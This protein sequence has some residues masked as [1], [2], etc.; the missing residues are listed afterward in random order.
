MEGRSGNPGTVDNRYKFISKERD[1]ETG[2]DWFDVRGFDARIGRFVRVDP[3]ADRTSLLGWSPY[4]YAFDNPLK[5]RDET[6]S[7]P[8]IVVGLAA[9]MATRF[10]SDLP[11]G[12]PSMLEVATVGVGAWAAQPTLMWALARPAT[13]TA[14]TTGVAEAMLPGAETL[15]PGGVAAK[16]ALEIGQGL[17]KSVRGAFE[18]AQ[19]GGRHAGMLERYARSASDEILKGIRSYE[20]NV[21][22]HEGYLKDP[23]IKVKEFAKLSEREQKWNI[24]YWK[25]EIATRRE[26]IEVLRGILRERGGE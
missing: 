21:L 3:M 14:I 24:E 8:W 25:K 10:E 20:K 16:G 22:K 5:F 4:H 18:I 2:H 11:G 23:T 7:F 6:G 26:Q 9:W 19:E 1:M 13:A 17:S 12:S 15:T